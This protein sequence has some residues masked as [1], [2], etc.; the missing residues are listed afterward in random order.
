VVLL[1]N[2]A[3]TGRVRDD[4]LFL[5][6]LAEEQCYE[7][8]AF[9][10]EHT[11]ICS[12]FMTE[13][14]KHLNAFKSY[15]ASWL[16][17]DLDA[18]QLRSSEATSFDSALKPDG[19]NLASVLYN[20]NNT[21]PRFLR[22]LIEIT[23]ILEPNLD[24][25]NFI[26]PTQDQVFMFFEDKKGNRFSVS[27]VSSGTLR[28]LALAYVLLSI[29]TQ[30]LIWQHPHRLIVIEEPENGIYVRHLRKLTELIDPSGASGQFIFTSHSPY[31]IDLFDAHLENVVVMKRHETYSELTKLDQNKV[32]KYLEE[33][34]L[35]DLHFREM[36]T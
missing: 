23:R 15:L 29:T 18:L 36:L 27:S 6:G 24:L 25:I 10:P 31:F 12:L 3:G 13:A 32:E 7:K 33:M 34:P 22:R 35:G 11:A 28:F 9:S 17:Y 16:Y 8:I 2:Q 21:N 26:A 1:E 4:T 5:A 30:T 20:L 14:T 19:S